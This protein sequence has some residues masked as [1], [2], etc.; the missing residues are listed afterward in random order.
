MSLLTAA[1]SWYLLACL[2]AG[3]G[4]AWLLYRKSAHS[5]SQRWFLYVLAF[6]RATAVALVVLLLFN[7]YLKADRKVTEQPLVVMAFDNSASLLNGSDS[8]TLADQL[9]GFKRAAVDALATQH[10][11]RLLSFGGKIEDSLFFDFGEQ[12]TDLGMLLETIQKRH[13][14]PRLASVVLVTDGIYNRGMEPSGFAEQLGVPI[15][16]VPLGDTTIRRDL[17][18][19]ALRANQVVYLNSQF[20]ILADLEATRMAGS[21]AVVQLEKWDGKNFRKL[22]EQGLQVGSDRFFKTLQ[23]VAPADE[24]GVQRY[25][26]VL[27]AANEEAGQ[28]ENNSREIFVEVLDQ[29]T[30]LLILAHAPH[31]DITTI[32]Q[33]LAA[34][35]QYK[36]DLAFT[37]QAVQAVKKPDVV[38]LHQVPSSATYTKPWLDVLAKWEVPTWHILGSQTN[39]FDFNKLQSNLN[40]ST[41]MGAINKVQAAVSP[42]FRLFNFD[43]NLSE[44]IANLPPLDAVFGDYRLN[45]TASALLTQNIGSLQTEIPLWAFS[46]SGQTRTAVLAAEGLWR[47]HFALA[48]KQTR[49]NPVRDLIQR[50]VQFLSIKADKRPFRI[51]QNRKVYA[52]QE[53][54]LFEAELYNKNEEPVNEPEVRL[55]VEHQDGRLFQFSMGRSTQHYFLNA[56]ALPPGNY[57][58]EAQTKL[59]GEAFNGV[60]SFTVAALALEKINTTANHQLLATLA[61]RSGGQ[62]VSIDQQAELFELI[63]SN[64]Y[65]KPVVYYESSIRELISLEWLLLLIAGLM[66]LEWLIRRYAG[67]Y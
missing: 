4:Y 39:L 62:M 23:F 15:F 1:S 59:A 52:E 21:T 67:S 11:L 7:P 45:P 58:Y 8:A 54:I 37:S 60:G 36:I 44:Q 64:E 53:D 19:Q 57:T 9:I 66:S 48:E 22:A 10:D 49:N 26:L 61:E 16:T 12:A 42:A 63:K 56:G 18:I 17:R 3:A 29:R 41:R 5:L 35:P 47:W 20:S 43:T 55:Q 25:R 51:R 34:N 27:R 38:I 6:L 28:N 33:S 24:P 2:L 40:I 46:A 50:T 30:Q 32:K 31:P 13:G 14:G 65:A